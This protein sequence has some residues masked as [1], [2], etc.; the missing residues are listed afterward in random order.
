MIPEPDNFFKKTSPTT[1]VHLFQNCLPSNRYALQLKPKLWSSLEDTSINN[2]DASD[3]VVLNAPSVEFPLVN[4]VPST[5]AVLRPKLS[6]YKISN[7][8]AENIW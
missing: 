3:D 2:S 8:P 4:F 6:G 1:I 7:S 5:N